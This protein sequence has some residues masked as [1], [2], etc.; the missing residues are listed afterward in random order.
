MAYMGLPSFVKVTLHVSQSISSN[1]AGAVLVRIGNNNASM[2]ATVRKIIL[3][4]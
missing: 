1:G 4:N 2:H 3:A